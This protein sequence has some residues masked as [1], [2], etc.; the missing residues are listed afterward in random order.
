MQ[1]VMVPATKFLPE[2]WVYVADDK[3]EDRRGNLQ[4]GQDYLIR[5][6]HVG[7]QLCYRK[8]GLEDGIA[9]LCQSIGDLIDSA[10]DS[11]A[12]VFDPLFD[13]TDKIFDLLDGAIQLAQQ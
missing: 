7:A 5:R 13:L 8:A 9:Q 10:C 3:E 1:G 2:A 12:Q 6:L 11:G 4:E